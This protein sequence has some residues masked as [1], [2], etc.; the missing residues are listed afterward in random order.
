MSGCGKETKVDDL[1]IEA[2]APALLNGETQLA[3]TAC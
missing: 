2:K 3:R 1:Q